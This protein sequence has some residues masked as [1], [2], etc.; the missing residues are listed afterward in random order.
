MDPA[1][2][3]LVDRLAI[4][5]VVVEVDLQVLPID[6]ETIVVALANTPLEPSLAED[7]HQSLLL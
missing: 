2:V 4:H 7:G 1:V 3:P 6:A 5:D